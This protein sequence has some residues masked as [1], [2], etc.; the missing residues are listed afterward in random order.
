MDLQKQNAS[1][2][3]QSENSSFH[4]VLQMF[5]VS[6]L[7]SFIGTAVGTNLVDWGLG[8]LFL[9][10]I[11]VQLGMLVAAFFVRRKG[12]PVGY[13]FVYTFTF[14]VGITI[15]PAIA[16]YAKIGGAG[17]V[18]AAFGI[19]TAIFAA[20][21]VYAYFSKRD[22]SFLGGMLFVGLIALI[23]ISIVSIFVPELRQGFVGLAIAFLGIMIFSGFVLYD[24]S[25]YKEG[26]PDE[27]IPLAVLS[28]YLNFINIFLY[29]LQFLGIL[30]NDD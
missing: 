30:S 28:L 3:V 15:Y 22:F 13:F 16:A 12:R 10:L 20:L 21:T 7:V 6:I 24:V 17:L 14:I 9:P 8:W 1:V 25:K 4:K 11:F 26:L 27:Y 19:T 5:A 23:G 29:V 2:L 18:T